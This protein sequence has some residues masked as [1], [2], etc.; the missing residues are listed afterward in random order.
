LQK[1]SD[2]NAAAAEQRERQIAILEAQLAYDQESG[3]I[4]REAEQIVH[5]SL[6][7]I[8]SG[9]SPLDTRMGSIITG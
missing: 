4:A 3:E 5:E 7:Q 8:N 2:D 9:V 6:D 1:L